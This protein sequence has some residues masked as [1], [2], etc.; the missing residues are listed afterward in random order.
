M[1]TGRPFRN[2][3]LSGAASLRLITLRASSPYIVESKPFWM[4]SL[5][6]LG[7]TVRSSMISIGAASEPARSSSAR[8]RCDATIAIASANAANKSRSSIAASFRHSAATPRLSVIASERRS[9]LA[10]WIIA[11]MIEQIPLISVI[12]AFRSRTA[13]LGQVAFSPG[14]IRRL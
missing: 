1:R 8:S 3:M 6:R 14:R 5:P 10:F 9:P 4:L 13:T 12:D 2:W 7:P 11:K